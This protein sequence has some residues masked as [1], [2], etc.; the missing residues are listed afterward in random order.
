MHDSKEKVSIQQDSDSDLKSMPDDDLR[1]VFEFEAGDSED[2]HKLEVSRSE[3]ISQDE[4]ASAE[5]LSIPDHL[6]HIYEEVSSLHSKLRDMESFIV[7]QVSI[8]IESSLLALITNAPGPFLSTLKECLPSIIKESMPFNISHAAQSE[9]FVTLQKELSKVLKSEMGQ[10]VTSKVRLGMEEV[11]DDISSQSKHQILFE[12]YGY[13]DPAA[14][15]PTPLRDTYK[16]KEVATEEPKNKLVAYMEEGG[17][18]QKKM[19]Q[20]LGPLPPPELATFGMTAEDKKRKRTEFLK[21]VFVKER[22]EVDRSQRNL[23]P[24]GVV[25][26]KDSEVIRPAEC[27]ALAEMQ[28]EFDYSLKSRRETQYHTKAGQKDY[29]HKCEAASA[30]YEAKRMK[31]LGLLEFKELEFLMIDPFSLLE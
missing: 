1:H 21:E 11:R 14:R 4:N 16:G 22:I 12:C 26:K 19:R 18:D 2:T 6:D 20:K 17:S 5:R 27:K 29:R 3:H 31:E 9:R 7:Q 8:E 23:T 25:G 15:K 28:A 30:A 24:H 10:S 13:A